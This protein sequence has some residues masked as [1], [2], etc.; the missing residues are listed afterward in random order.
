[1]RHTDTQ[2]GNPAP[3]VSPKRARLFV[4][5]RIDPSDASLDWLERQNIAVTRG[6]ALWQS[7]YRY[8]EEEV[9]SAA[10]GHDA[11]M[12][13]SGARFTRRVIEALPELRFI[14]KLGIGVETIDMAAAC[15][16]GVL[17]SNTPN[18]LSIQAVAEHTIGFMLQLT[19]NA[20]Y[21]TPRYMQSGGWRPG[22]FS[23][24]LVD[25]TIGLIGLGRIAREIA[26]RLAGWDT[27]IL[28]YDPFIT[29]APEGVTMTDFPTL[30]GSSDIVSLHASPS[31]DNRH[32]INATALANM[33]KSALLINVGRAWLVD[34]VALRNALMDGTI[35]GAALD[36]FDVEP[37][38]PNDPLF[39][40]PNTLFSPHVA[41]WARTALEHTGW[42]GAQN[43]WSM[44]N[45][46]KSPYI[47]N[48][49]VVKT[50][51]MSSA[52][53]SS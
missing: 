31:A 17:V 24:V 16:R 44:V 8:S 15:A 53:K 19:K 49:E 33:K 12:G 23:D 47:L 52:E 5:D 35:A 27:K 32:L 6:H 13:A 37:P 43:V 4:Y 26:K 36:V 9:I 3:A 21:W 28:A 1:M 42:R 7:A 38:D 2:R 25:K 41:A 11:V 50:A 34:T 30:L 10:Y 40:C 39:Q 22:Y 48:P 14:S 29:D 46:E 45:G 51:A 20:L 18:E